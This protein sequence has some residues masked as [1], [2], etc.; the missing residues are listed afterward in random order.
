MSDLV[1][2]YVHQVGRYLPPKDRAD[3]EAELHSQI[4]DQLDDHYAGSP[5]AD[6]IASMLLTYG[7]P[8]EVASSYNNAKHLIGPALYPMLIM[9]LVRGWVVIPTVILFL[10]VF[11]ALISPE[12]EPLFDVVVSTIVTI[13]QIT[14]IFSAIVILI[15]ALIERSNIEFDDTEVF[16]DPLNLPEVNPPNAIDRTEIIFGL[17]FGA[18]VTLVLLYFLSVGGLTLNFGTSNPPDLIPVS[19]VWLALLIFLSIAM[20]S[21]NFIALRR[22]HWT[23]PFYLLET[24]LE[25]TGVICFYFV[26]YQPLAQPIL[27]AIPALNTIPFINNA[28]ELLAIVT[29]VG[30]LFSRGSKLVAIW[31]YRGTDTLPFTHPSTN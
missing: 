16:F 9:V 24:V 23:V 21:L 1:E 27:T 11:G 28:P 26:F 5:T 20:I 14:L 18:F 15:F 29:A 3:I 12:A 17:P 8:Y 10:M 25:V 31:N 30:T 22:E 13:T 2:R 6:D 19:Q 4:Q 7:H